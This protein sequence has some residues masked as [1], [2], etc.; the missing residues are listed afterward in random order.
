MSKSTLMTQI[1]EIRNIL[2]QHGFDSAE[3]LGSGSYSSV[4]LCHSSKYNDIFSV[5]RVVRNTV[6]EL[7]YNALVSLNH[8]HIIKLYEAFD[9]GDFKYL[10]ME[11]CSQGNLKEKGKLDRDTFISYSK[12]VLEALSVCHSKMIAHRDIKPEN[13]FLDKYNRIKL[14]DFGFAR[15]FDDD[16]ISKE[17]CGSM[18]YSAPEIFKSQSVDPFLTDIWSLGTTFF[19][20]ATGQFPFTNRSLDELKNAVM[21][22]QIDYNQI[23]VDQRIRALI[24]KMTSIIPQNRPTIENILR[25][26]LY[27]P[28]SPRIVKQSVSFHPLRKG[29]NNSPIKVKSFSP[30]FS[31]RYSSDKSECES[32]S[33]DEPDNEPQ[34]PVKKVHT[35]R[36]VICI[37]HIYKNRQA[38]PK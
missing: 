25:L 8:P 11:Y 9:H 14:A 32:N 2:L 35:Y 1:E 38:F 15:K 13:I 22:G 6:T 26:P 5:K 18:M 27:T 21:K 24:M 12:Q 10:V 28:L 37:P 29:F 7:E 19:Y 31:S 23:D 34:I 3:S 20:M 4:F 30:Q 16:R 33:P 36:S 17:K